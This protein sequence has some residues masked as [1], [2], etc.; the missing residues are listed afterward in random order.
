MSFD[1]A[2]LERLTF[3]L[4]SCMDM[5]SYWFLNNIFVGIIHKNDTRSKPPYTGSIQNILKLFHEVCK[6]KQ[7]LTK[8]SCKPKEKH[9][10]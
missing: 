6:S 10:K 3:I 4:K 8:D 9:I 7:R 1:G 2:K 5:L